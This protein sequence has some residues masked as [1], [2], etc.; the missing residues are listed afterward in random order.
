MKTKHFIATLLS[1]MSITMYGQDTTYV[2]EY[3]SRLKTRELAKA[4]RI[5]STDTVVTNG[6]V[7]RVYYLSGKL[8]SELYYYKKLDDK[9]NKNI[10]V[11]NGQYQLWNE[12][13]KLKTECVYKEGKKDGL[14]ATYWE[15]G[16]PKRR[17]IYQ[18]GELLSGKCYDDNG[19]EVKYYPYE[20]LPAY[21]E[22]GADGLMQFL[23]LNIRY[24][25]SAQEAG[26]QGKV[27]VGF[28]IKKDGSVDKYDILRSLDA[29]TDAESIR[30]LS[31]IKRWKPA[32]LDGEAVDFKYTLPVVYRLTKSTRVV[33][34]NGF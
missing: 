31:L 7:E 10:N 19:G 24:P 6:I 16:K 34:K 5:N 28:T 18:N 9:T 23:R 1:L 20:V 32:I 4:Y 15:N 13:G 2:D 29:S 27:I 11:R 25:I 33:N 26:I 12:N 30:V 22:G 14:F 3:G 17:D 8:K 21:A